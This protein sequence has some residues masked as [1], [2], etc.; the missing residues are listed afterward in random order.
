MGWVMKSKLDL[1]RAKANLK[2][3]IELI[4]RELMEKPY[5]Y[6]SAAAAIWIAEDDV[7]D[8]L[9]NLHDFLKGHETVI[10]KLDRLRKIEKRRLL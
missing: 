10:S 4:D 3:A 2:I 7:L 8:A 5:T 6:N 9:L 1:K